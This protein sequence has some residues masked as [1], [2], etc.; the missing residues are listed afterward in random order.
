MLIFYVDYI[1]VT[2]ARTAVS[3]MNIHIIITGF[4]QPHLAEKIEIARHNREQY[5]KSCYTTFLTVYAY[6]DSPIPD[7]LFDEI[8]R[9]R[10]YVGEFIYG[11]ETV[12]PVFDRIMLILDDI[13]WISDVDA[14]LSACEKSM[15]EKGGFGIYQP[16]LSAN[17]QYSHPHMLM[18]DCPKNHIDTSFHRGRCF[19]YFCYYM[20]PETFKKYRALLTPKTRCMWGLDFIVPTKIPC[21]LFQA[22]KIRHWFLGGM[23]ERWRCE[24]EMYS[25]LG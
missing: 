1:L 2:V 5:K 15:S 17:S 7:G 16:S 19:E 3:F 10:G 8:I 13:E 20:T 4:G 24:E 14:Y 18:T 12:N 9:K 22:F 23:M 11:L 6:D 25:L 21:F